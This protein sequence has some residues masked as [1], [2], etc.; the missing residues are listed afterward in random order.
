MLYHL[1]GGLRSVGM[2]GQRMRLA[3]NG[4]KVFIPATTSPTMGDILQ[5]LD[6][7]LEQMQ[8]KSRKCSSLLPGTP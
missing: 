4:F 8:L 1:I 2:D 6:G 3:F 7:Q 5:R